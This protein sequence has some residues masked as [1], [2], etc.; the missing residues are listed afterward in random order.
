MKKSCKSTN[1]EHSA[2]DFNGI[3]LPIR[4][5]THNFP[6]NFYQNQIG[7]DVDISLAELPLHCFYEKTQFMKYYIFLVAFCLT[8][9]LFAQT[10][11]QYIPLAS[12]GEIPVDFTTSATRKYLNKVEQIP[13]TTNEHTRKNCTDFYLESSFV[14]DNLLLSGK[15]LFNDPISHYVQDIAKILLKDD[16]ATFNKMRFYAVRSETINAF[17]TNDGIVL[18]NVALL[19]HL[20]SEAQLA[21]ILAHEITHFKEQHALDLFLEASAEEA[22]HKDKKSFFKHRRTV[23]PTL[24]SNDYSKELEMEADAQGFDLFKQSGYAYDDIDGIYDIL[25]FS[26]QAFE[27][28]SFHKSFFETDHLKFPDAYQLHEVADITGIDEEED[29]I[30]STHPSIAQRRDA[31]ARKVSLQKDKK[32]AQFLVSEETF[33]RLRNIARYELNE[34]H[35]RSFD[36]Y[37]AIYN[38]YLL[39]DAPDADQ[40]YLKKVIAKSLYG[41]VKFRNSGQRI[42]TMVPYQE[43]EGAYQQLCYFLNKLKDNELNVLALQYA[44]QL[45]PLFPEDQEFQTMTD[46][47]FQ[48]MVSIHYDSEKVFYKKDVSKNQ[49]KV[50]NASFEHKA[51]SDFIRYAFV[52]FFDDPAFVS[53]FKKCSSQKLKKDKERAKESHLLE[54]KKRRTIKKEIRKQ[55]VKGQALGQQRIL[56]VNPYYLKLDFRTEDNEINRLASEKARE[57]L[58]KMIKNNTRKA[59]IKAPILDFTLLSEHDVSSF[60]DLRQLTEWFNHQTETDFPIIAF[61]QNKVDAIA[62]KYDTDYILWLGII[63]GE[64]RKDMLGLF[65][66]IYTHP[67]YGFLDIFR[68]SKKSVIFALVLNAKTGATEMVKLNQVKKADSGDLINAHLYDLFYQIE[69][70]P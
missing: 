51:E 29:D 4:N 60:N 65:S 27:N 31:M 6:H 18:F 47:L 28:K 36:F 30:E 50:L 38:A 64:T 48:E 62:K 45:K 19:A 22:Q 34:Y 70:E 14:V 5:L 52:D 63:A 43:A 35:L 54:E 9:G 11:F 12:K 44:W 10:G 24:S 55:L 17:A 67:V 33:Y 37:P 39:S 13:H 58:L 20:K 32:D 23:S 42:N 25:K 69:R 66:K 8:G 41:L 1:P 57:N 61:N 40:S 46:E 26:E 68:P 49:V 53:Q 2:S 21:F 56:V 16:L 59:T 7:I 15:V 3:P